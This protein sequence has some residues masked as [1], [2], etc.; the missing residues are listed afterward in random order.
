MHM[1]EILLKQQKEME[2]LKVDNANAYQ[3]K[4]EV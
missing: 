2:E 3:A 4:N 1:E